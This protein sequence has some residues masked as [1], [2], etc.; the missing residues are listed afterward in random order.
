MYGLIS[1]DELIV[2]VF[3]ESSAVQPMLL[4]ISTDVLMSDIS[5][6]FSRTVCPPFKTAAAIIGRAAFFE[7]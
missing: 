5:G 6:Q 2:S 7:P 3:P 1:P 4:R